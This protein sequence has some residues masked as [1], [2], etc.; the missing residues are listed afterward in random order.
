M[1]RSYFCK[2]NKIDFIFVKEKAVV[3]LLVRID[4][5][6]YQKMHLIQHFSLLATKISEIHGG[7]QN[8]RFFLAT[9][10]IFTC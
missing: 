3:L 7:D 1:S 4:N 9:K 2:N 6:V 10:A 8:P 5:L